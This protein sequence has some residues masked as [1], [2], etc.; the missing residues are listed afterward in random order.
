MS[1]NKMNAATI[2]SINKDTGIMFQ[3]SL[4]ISSAAILATATALPAYAQT[5]A[6]DEI[7]VTATK[8]TSTLQQ[9]PVAVT[10]T[11]ADVIEKARIL[12]IKDLQSVVPTLKVS[13]L[14]NAA[15]T[16]LSI[17]GFA[18][19]SNNVGIEPSV[20]LFIDGVYRS[21][22][23]SQIGDLP[24]LER[25]EVLSGPQSTLFGKNASAGVVSIVTQKPQFETQGHI[26]AGYGNYDLSTLEG[27]ITG[28]ISEN[29]AVSLG[30]GYQKRDGYGT[31][32]GTNQDINDLNRFNLRGQL[33][34]EPTD[35]M[36]W[37]LIGDLSTLDEDCCL[38]ATSVAGPTAGVVQLLGGAISDPSDPF[39]NVTPLNQNT[40]NDYEDSGVSLQG[41]IDLGFATLT[42]ISAYRENSGGFEQSDSDFTSLDI[43]GNVFQDVDIETFTQEFRLTSNPSDLP[44]DWMIG[45]FYFN[46]DIVQ[47]SGAS[48]GAD[49]RNYVNILLGAATAGTSLEGTTLE[50][51][52]ATVSALPVGSSYAD[53]AGSIEFFEQ[54][55][56]A[57]SIFGTVDY[58]VTDKLTLSGG[59]NYTQ[60]KKNVSGRTIND[61]AFAALNFF[62]A[63]GAEFLTPGVQVGVAQSVFVNGQDPI[64]GVLPDG[65]PSFMAAFGLEPTQANFDLLASGI[66]GATAQAGFAQYQAGV[67]GF[68]AAAAPGIALETAQ[69]GAL[70][71][72]AAIQFFNPFTAFPNAVEDG[73]T[74]DDDITYT[75]KAAYEVNDNINVYGSYATGFKSSSFNL[76]R[77]SLPFATDA[78]ALTVAGLE[79]SNPR[80]GTRFAG[81]EETSVFELGLK[82]RF[83]NGALNVAV[84]DQ[85]I[86]GFQSTIFVGTG[87]Q[88][89]NAGRQSVQG[90]EF[91]GTYTLFEDLKLGLAGALLDAQFDEFV[92]AEGPEG[93]VDLSGEDV[94][95]V[96]EIA[97]VFS[98]LYSFDL[99]DDIAAYVRA[100]YQYE[101]EVRTNDNLPASVTRE[102]ST[103]NASAGLDFA[104]GV[105]L[106]LWVRN[107]TNDEFFTS[108][109]PGPAQ[110]GTFNSYPNQ[111][112]TYGAVLRYNF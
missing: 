77:N 28:P 25:I 1:R 66:A 8:R 40:P 9:T 21:R 50:A 94:S 69:S 97:L 60:D 12:D 7:I 54:D 95:G 27:Y 10:V 35:N 107:L 18:N 108:G 83:E 93:P 16:T 3:K 43:L 37:R 70:A 109:F 30:G 104:N 20:G 78:E 64:P 101:D 23:A 36:S 45:G 68:A 67:N 59:L 46:E 99:S 52:E 5:A 76:T 57:Y 13:Q 53:G 103:I 100:D 63:D 98:A 74:N 73:R 111:P 106:Q 44:F 42:T 112:R 51:I 41:D 82:T 48:Y 102:V 71:G 39:S 58:R 2:S 26:E 87:F 11:S 29:V 65:I 62:D 38:V 75:L 79:A 84:F 91:D 33:L 85:E 19:G 89:Q 61:D 22:A 55:S 90:I 6:D 34:F 49:T 110:A 92:G 14:Q 81:P 88:L 86:E 31:I 4:L 56:E 105:A 15:N 24:V 17:R 96:P 72:I 32:A 80:F 47:N